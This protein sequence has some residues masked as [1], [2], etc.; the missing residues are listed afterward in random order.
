MP[1]T[2]YILLVNK[3]NRRTEFQIYW[4]YDSTCFGQPFHP[5]SGV[6]SRRSALVHFMQLWPFAT[7]SRMELSSTL[8]LV[9][10]GHQNC[11][12]CTTADVRLRTLMMGRKA[13][14]NMSSHNTNKFGI[15]CVCWF[16]SQGICHDARSYDPK[17]NSVHKLF[18]LSL[19]WPGISK[20]MVKASLSLCTPWSH[21]GVAVQF[22]SFLT[23]ALYE[24][25][26]SA[27]RPSRFSPRKTASDTYCK[28]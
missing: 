20:C 17:K 9:A 28:S 6:L 1:N 18:N 21:V 15:Q 14:R 25:E 24:G 16:Y 26:W 4:Y 23:S 7:R 3:T 8:L 2:L 27:S 22:H 10:N 13:A 5:S 12:K 19:I 11:I